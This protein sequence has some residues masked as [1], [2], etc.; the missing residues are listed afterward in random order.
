MSYLHTEMMVKAL[1]DRIGD[2][3]NDPEPRHDEFLQ[4]IPVH[5]RQQLKFALQDSQRAYTMEMVKG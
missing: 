3:E 4:T 5:V 1:L 2:F